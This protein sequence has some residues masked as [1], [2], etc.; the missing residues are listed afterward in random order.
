MLEI[1]VSGWQRHHDA[2]ERRRQ[3]GD[4][5]REA[6]RFSPAANLLRAIALAVLTWAVLAALLAALLSIG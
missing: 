4:D 5:L 6:D 3:A 1:A 2:V